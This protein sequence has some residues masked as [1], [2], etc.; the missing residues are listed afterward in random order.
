VNLRKIFLVVL[1]ASLAAA[2]AMGVWGIIFSRHADEK[3]IG[4][5]LS[6]GLFSLTLL[7]SAI[8]LDKR[9]WMA[10]MLC[11]FGVSGIGLALFLIE[12][13]LRNDL[14]FEAREYVGRFMGESAVVA[15][16][17]PLAGLL[18]LTAFDQPVLRLVRLGGIT[19]VFICAA[20]ISIPIWADHYVG[21]DFFKFVAVV[22]IATALAVVALPILHKLAGMPP[23]SETVSMDVTMAIV[24][25]RCA[26]SQTVAAGP[27]R[28]HRCRLKFVIE[29]EEPRCPKCRYL[30]FQLTEPRC[31]ECGNKLDQEDVVRPDSMPVPQAAQRV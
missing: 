5:M 1:L 20:T 7:G 11:S 22:A 6:I 8:V 16:A 26:L 3:L 13:W 9:R 2:A 17:L 12:I 24:C 29:I 4:S 23:P 18:A 31:P 28:C 25:P 15:I 14:S 30:L 19:L 27:S 21:D 10:A